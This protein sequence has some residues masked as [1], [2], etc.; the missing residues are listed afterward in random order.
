MY[1]FY[2]ILH[3]CDGYL[4]EHVNSKKRIKNVGK[5][6]Q[7]MYEKVEMICGEMITKPNVSRHRKLC[8]H[9]SHI[10]TLKA[11]IR[12]QQNIIQFLKSN[13]KTTNDSG[14]T[15]D[16]LKNENAKLKDRCA[17]YLKLLKKN[18]PKRPGVSTKRKMKLLLKQSG[19]CNL[20][21]TNLSEN[22]MDCDHIIRWCDSYDQSDTNLQLI[23]LS[24][25]RKKTVSEIGG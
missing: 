16:D 17:G 25:H 2:E 12:E 13:V 9:C 20:C 3:R 1:L 15:N 22:N 7:M 23:C 4:A 21:S 11:Q 10:K 18:P 14:N 24:C 8:R 5:N 6:N 19:K